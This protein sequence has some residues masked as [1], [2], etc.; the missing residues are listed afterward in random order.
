MRGEVVDVKGR[1]VIVDCYNANPASMAAALRALAE[2]A[3]GKRALAVLGDML[4][5]GDH[6]IPEHDKIGAL[7]KDLGVGV[8]TIGD[9]AARIGSAA[10]HA[11]DPASAAARALERTS[12]GDWILLKASRGMKLERVLQAMREGTT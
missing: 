4:E 7:A 3:T 12:A 6:G 1:K 9:L 10:D 2:R 11:A 8:V 5:L